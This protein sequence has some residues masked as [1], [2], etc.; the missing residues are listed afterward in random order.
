[1]EKIAIAVGHTLAFI[2]GVAVPLYLHVLGAYVM[3]KVDMVWG[4]ISLF[5]PPLG[6]LIGIIQVLFY[7]NFAPW[8]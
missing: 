5:V 8:L 1:M 3:F 7:G 4:F 6:I 2:I